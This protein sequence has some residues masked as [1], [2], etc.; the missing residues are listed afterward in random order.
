[1]LLK[2]LFQAGIAGLALGGT[3]SAADDDTVRL[4]RA[5][6]TDTTVTAIEPSAKDDEDTT[7]TRGYRGGYGWGGYGRSY[8]YGGWGGYGRGW[9]YGGYGYGG[10][11][12]G[13]YI[14]VGY[15][16]GWGGYGGYG[17]GSYYR[18]YWGGYGYGS[19]YRPYWGGYYYPRYY[20]YGYGY[21]SLYVSAYFPI[22]GADAPAVN[23]AN[24]W[25][26]PATT[27]A[28]PQAAPK[29]DASET[30]KIS[31]PAPRVS[32]T[33]AAFGEK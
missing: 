30:I 8:G 9:G 11:G 13:T 24:G 18:P 5:D 21:P 20:S 23:L 15:G 17:Y 1:M 16:R 31:S 26:V 29:A 28:A 4:G 19:Y 10:W 33:Y 7:L 14:S 27:L 32:V 2:R 3:A 12:R 6:A 25:D 22:A